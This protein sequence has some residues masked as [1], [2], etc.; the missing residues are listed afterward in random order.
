MVFA[1]YARMNTCT[2]HDYITSVE[3]I[4]VLRS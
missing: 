4:N 3:R 1:V 2:M